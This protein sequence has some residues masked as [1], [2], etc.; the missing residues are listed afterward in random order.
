MTTLTRP[1]LVRV[2]LATGL[3]LLCAQQAFAAAPSPLSSTDYRVSPVCASQ[4]F[5]SASCLG[6]RLVAKAPQTVPGVRV[7]TRRASSIQPAPAIEYKEPFEGSLTPSELLSAYGLS[8]APAPAT[9]QTIAII[10]AYDDPTAEQDLQHFDQQFELPE[11][12]TANGCFRKVN[13]E[14]KAAPLPESNSEGLEPEAGWALEIATDVEMAHSVCQACKVLLVEAATSSFSDMEEAENTAV[15]LGA[16]A[17]SNSWGGPECSESLCISDSPAFNHPGVVITASSGDLGYLNW[18]AVNAGE[19]GAADYPASSPHVIAVG[20]TRLVQSSGEWQPETIWNDGGESKTGER[21]GAGAAGG[22]CSTA[23]SAPAWQR[24]LPAWEGVG[25]ANRRAVAD[26]AADADPYTGVAVYDSTPI[27]E[28]AETVSGWNV[29][30]GTSVASPIIASTF[31]LAG[32]GNGVSYPAR[33]LYSNAAKS[34]SAFHDV[35]EGSNGECLKPFNRNT[36]ESGCTSLEQA[37]ICKAKSICLAGTGYDGPSG[38]GT[39]NGIAAFVPEAGEAEESNNEEPPA[40]SEEAPRLP[41]WITNGSGATSPPSTPPV[42]SAPQALHVP[43]LVFLAL[44]TRSM[45]ALNGARPRASRV[46]FA[47]VIDLPSRVKVLLAKRAPHRRW[48][49][50]HR[51]SVTI[52][53]TPGRN[54]D[55]LAGSQV[56]AP[57]TYRL[58]LTPQQGAARS[59]VF[60]IG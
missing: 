38:V 9:T 35:Q 1:T 27:T 54:S 21:G 31:A 32:G 24:A 45:I 14:G 17:I 29:L 42:L 10:D 37:T 56:L 22:G 40:P 16:T 13:Q 8:S 5:G 47:F 25:C 49:A 57:G 30:G 36:A 50:L 15:H 18:D 43:H 51:A 58:T 44:T 6:L 60:H 23:F 41:S 19:R 39:P 12:T 53:A 4:G 26:I 48:R 11:C 34:A 52:S 7:M 28:G 55:K 20:G 2:A 33:T 59:L 3:I 46:Q